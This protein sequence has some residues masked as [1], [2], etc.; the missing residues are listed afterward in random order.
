M[1]RIKDHAG[2]Y[3]AQSADNHR[4]L[5]A[6]TTAVLRPVAEVDTIWRGTAMKHY[7]IDKLTGWTPD[8]NPPPETPFYKWPALAGMLSPSRIRLVAR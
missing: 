4:A 3:I 5:L 2:L 7:Q 8:L 6:T 1:D